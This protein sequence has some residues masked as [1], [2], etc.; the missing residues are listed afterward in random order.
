[1]SAATLPIEVGTRCGYCGGHLVMWAASDYRCPVCAP[2]IA[3]IR[4]C[5]EWAAWMHNNRRKP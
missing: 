5:D 3:S 2:Q 4:T 1:M